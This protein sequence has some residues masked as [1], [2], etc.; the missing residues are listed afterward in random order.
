MIPPESYLWVG[1]YPR[2]GLE[3]QMDTYLHQ[4]RTRKLPRGLLASYLNLDSESWSW[5]PVKRRLLF[6][7]DKCRDQGPN[8]PESVH[9]LSLGRV[10]TAL[11]V[12]HPGPWGTGVQLSLVG[13]WPGGGLGQA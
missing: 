12:S 13:C 8:P 4:R 5:G 3:F 10:S 11:P 7:D 2:I 1:G 9:Q 6:P